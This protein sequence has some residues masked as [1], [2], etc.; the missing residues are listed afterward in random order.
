MDNNQRKI[1]ESFYSKKG[2]NW[3]RG[4]LIEYK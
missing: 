4:H 3:I 1:F 2:D